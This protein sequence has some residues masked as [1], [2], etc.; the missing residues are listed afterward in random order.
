MNDS[1]KRIAENLVTFLILGVAVAVVVGL[2]IMLSYV[3]LWGLMI[4]AVMWLVS[5]GYNY[6]FATKGKIPADK[7]RI[8]EH[9][10]NEK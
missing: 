10:D 6:L 9:E 4:G 1:Y 3:I 2:F 7:G 8:I 5:L